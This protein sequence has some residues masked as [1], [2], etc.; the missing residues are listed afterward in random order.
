MAA[1]PAAGNDAVLVLLVGE[2]AW[3]DDVVDV[4]VRTAA[5]PIRSIVDV[6]L[7]E[8]G[9]EVKEERRL[10]CHGVRAAEVV[11]LKTRSWG[12]R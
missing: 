9:D 6:D 4:F 10:R 11:S 2:D 7:F 1:A 3:E 12:L 8:G 5:H